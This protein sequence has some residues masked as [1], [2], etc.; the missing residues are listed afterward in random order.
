MIKN[1]I[2]YKK[3]HSTAKRELIHKNDPKLSYLTHKMV[4][5]IKEKKNLNFRIKKI[6]WSE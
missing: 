6:K 3:I 4:H 1:Q 5:H 2:F